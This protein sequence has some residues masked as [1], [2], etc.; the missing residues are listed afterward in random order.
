[1]RETN[2]LQPIKQQLYCYLLLSFW[3]DNYKAPVNSPDINEIIGVKYPPH[4]R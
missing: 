2:I 3:F 1:M 4:P